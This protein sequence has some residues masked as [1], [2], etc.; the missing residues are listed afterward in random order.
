MKGMNKPP[1]VDATADNGGF[2]GPHRNNT[3]SAIRHR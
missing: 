2:T 1:I 3:Y